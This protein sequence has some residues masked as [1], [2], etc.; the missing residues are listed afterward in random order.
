MLYICFHTLPQAWR[1]LNTDFP[2]YYLASRLV[3]E[4]YDTTRM[5]EWTWIE[6]EKDHRAIDIRVLGLLPITPFSTLAVLPL[7]K[8]APLTAKHVWI[9]LNLL[10]LVPLAWMLREITRLNL[11][12]IGLAL[13][14]N[15]PLYRNFLFGQFYIVLLL[16]V[17]AACWCYLRGYRAWAGALLAIAG[18][19]K[20]FPALLFIFFLRRR[21]WRALCAGLVAGLVAAASSIAVFGWTVHRTW[22]QEI[23]PWVT[24]G[25]GL[26]PYT[27]TA[28]VSGILHRLF[29]SEPQWNPRPWHNSPLAYALLFPV[30][31]MLILAPAILLIRRAQSDRNTI[32]LEWSALIT[33]AL[34]IS[35]IPASYNFVLMVFPVCVVASILYRRR[36]WGWLMLLVLVYFGIGCPISVPANISGLAVLLYVPRLPLLMGFLAGNYWL[37]YTDGRAAERSRDW[38]TYVWAIALIII[39]ISSVRSTLQVEQAQREEYAYRL[40]LGAEGFLNASPHPEGTSVRY[41]AFTFEGYRR[42]VV[43]MCDGVE[44]ISRADA[45]DILSSDDEDGHTLLERATAPQSEIVEGDRPLDRIVRDAHDPILALDGKS[46]AFLRDDHGRGRLMVRD[47]L[48]DVAPET[49][50]TP[51]QMNVYE[52][53][54]VSPTAYVYAAADDGGYPQLYATDGARADVPLGLGASR[55]PALSSDGRWLAYSHLDHGVW[56]LWIRSQSSGA[57][58]RVADV[59]CNQIQARWESDSKT[60]LYST[61]CGRSVWFTA[62]ARRKVIP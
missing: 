27:V 6:R 11:R 2:N 13:M 53:A 8:L 40:P 17:V 41:L 60:L 25:E 19:C 51:G 50:L 1:K 18:A 55:Y 39:T 33:A 48:G 28:S 46:L 3:D 20:I 29:L 58:R 5:Y 59:P 7:A 37:L 34:A 4:H 9:L 62:V 22:L 57:L 35:T 43:D 42:V 30:L 16:L 12:W 21:D 52:A 61:D 47:G 14:L 31:Q 44:A 49:A 54:Y 15:F 23:L 38:R 32:L 24:R 26:Q 36:C 45:D 56:N 10:I